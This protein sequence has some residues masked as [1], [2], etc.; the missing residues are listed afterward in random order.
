MVFEHAQS[1]CY[2]FRYI[3]LQQFNVAK[4][5]VCSSTYMYN[6]DRKQ[7]KIN[8]SFYKRTLYCY[9]LI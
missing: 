2:V 8:I 5:A 4:N 1:A 7:N 9:D 3:K 6:T